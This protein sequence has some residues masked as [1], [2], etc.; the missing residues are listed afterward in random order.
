MESRLKEKPVQNVIFDDALEEVYETLERDV[1]SRFKES[2][3]IK[4]LRELLGMKRSADDIL[5]H[6]HRI[7][8]MPD[9]LFN[10]DPDF[11]VSNIN[12]DDV[13]LDILLK[14]KYMVRVFTAY[15]AKL[16]AAENL[17]FVLSVNGFKKMFK[18]KDETTR[19]VAWLI[20]AAFV[21]ETSEYQV[22]TDRFE[23]QRIAFLLGNPRID[24]F[25]KVSE[26][27]Y[28]LQQSQYIDFKQSDDYKSLEK[29]LN[30]G[31]KQIENGRASPSPRSSTCVVC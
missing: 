26:D 22:S 29:A 14:D 8:V 1:L 21:S 30:D 16:H 28:A 25:D 4:V 31:K 19:E 10:T 2:D 20:Y 3:D 13:P 5:S 7:G 23:R 27:C 9:T 12:F 6:F 15:L 11:K 18:E 17:M 24:M